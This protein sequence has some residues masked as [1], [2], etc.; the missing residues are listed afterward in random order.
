MCVYVCVCVCVCMRV[1]AC[2][3][4]GTRKREREREGE[5]VGVG[6]VERTYVRYCQRDYSGGVVNELKKII[7]VFVLVAEATFQC[8]HG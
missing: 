2:V 3:R 6:V 7:L 5:G 8:S 1:W 4:K